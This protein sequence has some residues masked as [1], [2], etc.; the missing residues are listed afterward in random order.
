[1]SCREGLALGLEPLA[2]VVGL[3]LLRTPHGYGDVDLLVAT[4]AGTAVAAATA[5]GKRQGCRARHAKREGP[6]V[7]AWP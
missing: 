2:V 3:V 4:G 6:D 7:G 1:M 5:G